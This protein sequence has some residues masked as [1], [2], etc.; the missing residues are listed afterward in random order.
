MSEVPIIISMPDE[1]PKIYRR[2]CLADF[3]DED[4]VPSENA[5]NKY[6][7]NYSRNDNISKNQQEFGHRKRIKP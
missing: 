4:D 7:K 5:N 2:A 3:F 6:D 1:T